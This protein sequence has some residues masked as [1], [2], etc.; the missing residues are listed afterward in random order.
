M[1]PRS[2]GMVPSNTNL[3]FAALKAV[4]TQVSSSPAVNV[5][6]TAQP[7]PSAAVALSGSAPS[8]GI[9]DY[10]E[11]IRKARHGDDADKPRMGPPWIVGDVASEDASA[12]TEAKALTSSFVGGLNGMLAM[13]RTQ[14][15]HRAEGAAAQAIG[16]AATAKDSPGASVSTVDGADA[17]KVED[18]VSRQ[19]LPANRAGRS[20]AGVGVGAGDDAVGDGETLGLKPL[21]DDS[22]NRRFWTGTGYEK[23]NGDGINLLLL[24][25]MVDSQS[26]LEQIEA[27][28]GDDKAPVVNERLTPATVDLPGLGSS[29]SRP[30]LLASGSGVTQYLSS[31]SQSID[32]KV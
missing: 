22:G 32:T 11:Q 17:G 10:S 13:G 5:T 4:R 16:Q 29:P 31:A 1:S 8:A 15:H 23:V 18:T 9:A 26:L 19:P 27:E 24:K 20:T 12:V 28:K 7:V 2:I 3:E 30:D 25:K 6:R 14:F 21:I